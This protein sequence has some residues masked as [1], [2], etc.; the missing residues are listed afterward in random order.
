[1]KDKWTA[2]RVKAISGHDGQGAIIA[3]YLNDKK[4]A[5]V[6]DD[7]YGGGYQYE[8]SDNKKPEVEHHTTYLYG[9]NEGEPLTIEVTPIEKKFCDYVEAQGEHIWHK[10]CIVGNLVRGRK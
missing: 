2:K 7:G 3:L 6:T 10:D 9:E 8:W 4:V 1:M 5:D